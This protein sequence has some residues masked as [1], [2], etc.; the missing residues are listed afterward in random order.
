MTREEAKKIT[1][2]LNQADGS[3]PTCVRELIELAQ[4]AF[5]EF[6]WDDLNK[7]FEIEQIKASK[8]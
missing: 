6:I 3:C 4:E 5:P 2:I 8:E 1:S 7:E